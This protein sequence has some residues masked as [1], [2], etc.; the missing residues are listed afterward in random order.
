MRHFAVGLVLAWVGHATAQLPASGKLSESDGVAF[1]A[2]IARLEKMLVSAPDKATITYEIARTCAAGKQWPEAVEWL[3]KAVN[4]QAGFDPSRERLFAELRGSRE[5]T[6]VEA[7]ARAATPPIS[8]SQVAFQVAEGD[9]IP[10]SMAFDRRGRL[11]YFG[12]MTK[13]KVL[14]CSVAGECA[15]FAEGLGVVLGLKVFGDGL[16][17]LSNLDLESA[18][19]HFELS[20]GR[21]VRRY[22]VRGAHNFNDL[23]FAK[24]GDIYLTDTRA[25]A[26]WALNRG[27]AEL[28]RIPGEFGHAN[29]IALSGDGKLLYISTFPEGLTVVDLKTNKVQPV[30]RLGDLCLATIDGLYFYRGTLVAVQNALMS[31]RVV[32]MWLGKDL[33]TI[34]GFE[35]LER[36]NPLFDGVTTGV[37]VGNELFYM[38]NIQDEKRKTGLFRLPF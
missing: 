24:S 12:S 21:L 28:R 20:S 16:W 30:A 5:Y 1:R 2:E 18:V 3:G 26:V 34:E 13:G 38:A 17:G 33:R 32:R 27:A 25:G 8:R 10:E 15:T 31:P 19:V 6:A 35:V 11:F 29:G 14:R 23:A 22:A 36:R 37:I 9:L 7:A 4:S